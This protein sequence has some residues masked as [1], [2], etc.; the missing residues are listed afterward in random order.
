MGCTKSRTVSAPGEVP[1][2]DLD[3]CN[4]KFT[5]R[6]LNSLVCQSGDDNSLVKNKSGIQFKLLKSFILI[7]FF[8]TFTFCI[9]KPLLQTFQKQAMSDKVKKHFEI[10]FVC[11]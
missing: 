6:K 7:S 10:A 5:K 2:S 9:A 1:G 8:S 11:F 3:L 4:S